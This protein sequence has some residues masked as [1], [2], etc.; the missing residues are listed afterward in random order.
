MNTIKGMARDLCGPVGGKGR[1]R[2]TH[3]GKRAGRADSIAAKHSSSEMGSLTD[4]GIVCRSCLWLL[5]VDLPSR[6]ACLCPT[7]HRHVSTAP[8]DL[9]VEASAGFPN[10]A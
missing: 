4:I 6:P 5:D 1:A 7:A 9:S 3:G 10:R 8:R 2:R